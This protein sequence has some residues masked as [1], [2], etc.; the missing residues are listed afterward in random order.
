MFLC[1]MQWIR[2]KLKIKTR[3]SEAPETRVV[4]GLYCEE[5][6]NVSTYEQLNLGKMGDGELYQS[7]RG[8]ARRPENNETKGEDQNAYQELN[9]VEKNVDNNYQSLKRV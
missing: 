3:D 8:H 6:G 5:A 1:A 4:P 7:L 2:R 9:K